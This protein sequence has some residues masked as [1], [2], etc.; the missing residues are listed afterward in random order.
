MYVRTTMTI[1]K[2]L[3]ISSSITTVNDGKISRIIYSNLLSNHTS[4]S[5]MILKTRSKAKTF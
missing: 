3:M 5:L 4:H 2:S 1:A